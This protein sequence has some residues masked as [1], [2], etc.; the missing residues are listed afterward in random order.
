MTNDKKLSRL[1]FWIA[2]TM[3][4]QTVLFQLLATAAVALES[5][6]Y[7]LMMPEMYAHIIGQTVYGVCYFLSFAVPAWI[8]C[9][10]SRRRE[11]YC[12]GYYRGGIPATMPLIAVAAIAINFA[13]AYVNQA[14]LLDLFPDAF[15]AVASEPYEIYEIVMMVF[16]TAIVPAIVEEM[17]FRGAILTNL[18]PF[19]RGMAIMGSALLFGLMHGNP[20]Q[21]LYTSLLGVVLG[22]VYVKTKSIYVC[23][24]IHF[25]NNLISVLQTVFLQFS[26]ETLG[27]W[28]YIGLEALILV[29]GALSIV[30]FLRR[31]LRRPRPVQTGS[32]GRVFEPHADYA[33]Y[34]VTRGRR[35]ALFFSPAMIVYGVI[36]LG[37][38]ALSLLGIVLAGGMM[39]V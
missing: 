17:L 30:Y 4:L 23:M 39:Y 9:A 19:G 31:A 20:L 24:V 29:S 18:L 10:V 22:V 13:A 6:L 16:T 32:F 8:F 3:I 12:P 2:M 1:S 38:M 15:G 5:L 33:V 7:F 14:V 34:P 36:A 21:F 11:E 25:V 27:M 35:V 37:L 28:L 26:N